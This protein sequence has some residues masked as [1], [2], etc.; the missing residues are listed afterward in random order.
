MTL[1]IFS[2]GLWFT[3]K[4]GPFLSDFLKQF[5]TDNLG[6]FLMD[7]SGCGRKHIVVK[8]ENH[9]FFQN[10]IKIT[11]PCPIVILSND[12]NFISN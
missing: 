11:V 2:G 10:E 3:T 5:Q 8:S 6:L 4:M 12:R 7:F 1:L 9:I